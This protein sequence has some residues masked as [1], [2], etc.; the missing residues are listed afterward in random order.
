MRWLHPPG[1]GS[2]AVTLCVRNVDRR[3]HSGESGRVPVGRNA[4]EELARGDV[5]YGDGI[6]VALGDE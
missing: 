1:I 6:V 3:S 4:A 5:E 2:A